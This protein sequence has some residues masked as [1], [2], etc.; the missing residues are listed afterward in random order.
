MRILF[1]KAQVL[2]DIPIGI[3]HNGAVFVFGEFVQ[4]LFVENGGVDVEI[5]VIG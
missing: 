5:L 4:I 3:L 1:V 2:K